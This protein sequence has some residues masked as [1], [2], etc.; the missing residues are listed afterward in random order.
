MPYVVTQKGAVHYKFRDLLI[1]SNRES[2][3]FSHSREPSDKPL[4]TQS[5]EPSRR[6]I[7]ALRP[8]SSPG[9]SHGMD[10]IPEYARK[11]GKIERLG[12]P[13]FDYDRSISPQNIFFLVEPSKTSM[14]ELR[15]EYVAR[16]KCTNCKSAKPPRPCNRDEPACAYCD[17]H[18]YR[19][20]YP[21]SPIAVRDMKTPMPAI[22][23]LSYPTDVVTGI[24]RQIHW[25]RTEETSE[26]PSKRHL[27][28][29]GVTDEQNSVK[30][31]KE[32][33]PNAFKSRIRRSKMTS[34]SIIFSHYNVINMR[35]QRRVVQPRGQI[36][37]KQAC[38]ISIQ[39]RRDI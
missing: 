14:R 32:V 18:R 30:K 11:W 37:L 27:E 4:Y 7:S 26:I 16:G 19:C 2:P 17:R 22:P 6:L 15:G 39:K 25:Y 13:N 10:D 28:D 21:S 9:C 24:T 36:S 23:G 34:K 33:E 29:G 35:I 31:R 1:R 8:P 38:R 12:L 3:G 20:K 5:S